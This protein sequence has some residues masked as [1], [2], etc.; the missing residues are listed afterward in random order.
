MAANRSY[1]S[2]LLTSLVIASS[3]LRDIMS[4]THRRR[5]ATVELSLVGVGGVC[6]ALGY[7]NALRFSVRHRR[8]RATS[9]TTDNRPIHSKFYSSHVYASGFFSTKNS[10]GV[11]FIERVKYDWVQW[12]GAQLLRTL[13][14]QSTLR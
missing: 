4:N 5:D 11:T 3:R 14:V 1:S 6:W 13:S 8:V 7:C 2:V 12:L 10:D 9:K